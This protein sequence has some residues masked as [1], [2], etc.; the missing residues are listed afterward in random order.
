MYFFNRFTAIVMI[1]ALLGPALPLQAHTKK[2]DRFLTEGRAHEQ[3]KEWD[4][5]LESFQMALA[6]DPADIGYQMAMEKTRFQASQAHVERGLA[7]RLQGQ[8]GTGHR[9]AAH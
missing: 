2:G 5:A 7:I 6:E 9:L 1:A 4:L 8:L 3:K